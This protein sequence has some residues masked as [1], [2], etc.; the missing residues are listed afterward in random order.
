[1]RASIVAEK[2]NIPSVTVAITAFEPAAY[3]I[4]RAEGIADLRIAGYTGPIQTHSDSEIDQAIE[5]TVLDQIIEGLTKPA[6]KNG[7]KV[8]KP[9]ITSSREI[10]FSGNFE[11]VNEFFYRSGWT[12]GLP[13]IPPTV[14]KVEQFLEYTDLPL[15]EEV[16]V[17]PS[18]N[19]RA[20]PWNIAVNAVMAGCRPEYM[21]VLIAAVESIAAPA[22]RLKDTGTTASLRPYLLISGPIARQLEIHSGTGLITPGAGKLEASAAANPNSTIGRALFLITRNIAGFR[23]GISEMGV[24]GLPQSFVLAEDEEGSPW[25]PYHVEHGFKSN[26][27]TV[28]A[29]AYVAMSY[30]FTSDGDKADSHFKTIGLELAHGMHPAFLYF[31][32]DFMVNIL[33]AP[34]IA[35]VIAADGYS[36]REAIEQILNNAKMP[37]G[38]INERLE[39]AFQGYSIHELVNEGK[40]P[41]A[42]D[43]E[44]DKM[45]PVVS[46]ADNINIVVCG[47]HERGR[48]LIL[49]AVYT[50]PVTKEIKLPN[51]WAELIENTKG[52]GCDTECQI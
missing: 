27:S 32:P 4:A 30:A 16:A 38:S 23:P 11:G 6:E 14:D 22:F 45:I 29:M 31:A 33:I 26:A 52:C 40:I 50:R 15:N 44:P 36:K 43:I 49:F 28:T 9:G 48:C 41:E 42:L 8:V 37:V 18:A 1:M 2:A 39:L 12:D 47:S 51:N 21:P 7:A 10:V 5:K 46:Q 13:I 19:L 34:P 3:H 25:E 24:F 35:R 17:L 20:T